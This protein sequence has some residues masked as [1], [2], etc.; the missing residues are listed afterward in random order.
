MEL[1]IRRINTLEYLVH[2]SGPQAGVSKRRKLFQQILES[3]SAF[4][5][6]GIRRFALMILAV[7]VR[8]GQDNMSRLIA[9]EAAPCECKI[10]LTLDCAIGCTFKTAS[11]LLTSVSKDRLVAQ[12]VAEESVNDTAEAVHAIG[13]NQAVGQMLLRPD[14]T[15]IS[16][17]LRIL[18][19][20]K[21]I[22]HKLIEISTV[23]GYGGAPF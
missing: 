9:W 10:C 23:L 15:E 19:L 3:S 22:E 21:N 1:P 6:E 11:G 5:G 12:Y 20:R 18:L 2:G 16:A 7:L 13:A 8:E 4:G 14:G 17:A